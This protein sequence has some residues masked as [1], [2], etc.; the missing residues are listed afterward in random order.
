[1]IVKMKR[2]TILIGLVFLIMVMMPTSVEA[3]TAILAVVDVP[4]EVTV[5]EGFSFWIR[6]T[7]MSNDVLE[8]NYFRLYGIAPSGE[9]NDWG[10]H[11]FF[12]DYIMYSNKYIILLKECGYY[13]LYVDAGALLNSSVSII[14]I[15]FVIYVA[16]K[17]QPPD[18]TLIIVGLG[19][20]AII[21]VIIVIVKKR[22]NYGADL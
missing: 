1:M 9:E 8:Y 21:I 11:V 16:E 2:K 3:Q 19:S 4:N 12:D 7:S 5:K 17:I 22:R 10:I 14:T 6:L 15:G 18:Y 20:I 13:N